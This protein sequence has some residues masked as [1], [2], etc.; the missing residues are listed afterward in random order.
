LWEKDL[1]AGE[2]ITAVP[3]MIKETSDGGLLVARYAGRD[4]FQTGSPNR[5]PWTVARI[6]PE[7]ICT[8]TPLTTLISEE[9]L[10]LNDTPMRYPYYVRDSPLIIEYNLR[11]PNIRETRFWTDPKTGRVM[12]DSIL[13]PDPASYFNL[14]VKDLDTDS[15]IIKEKEGFADPYNNIYTKRVW[16]RYPGNYSIEFSGNRVTADVAFL[17]I[18][19]SP[20]LSPSGEMVSPGN[21]ILKDE[22]VLVLTNN[23]ESFTYDLRNTPLHVECTLTAPNTAVADKYL[24]DARFEITVKNQTTDRIVAQYGLFGA[25]NNVQFQIKDQGIYTITITGN[26]AIADV[27]FYQ[28]ENEQG[29]NYTTFPG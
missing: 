18:L 29:T 12:N 16:I 10:V 23:T 24:P 14:E 21:L 9:R 2:G 17:K 11:V 22:K 19:A 25:P 15:A 3:E 8:P 28:G 1:P 13:H 27:K 4:S 7:E 6:L 26:L 5:S 20:S